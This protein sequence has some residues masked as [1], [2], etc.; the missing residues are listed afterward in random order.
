MMGGTQMV[1]IRPRGHARALA[2]LILAASILFPALAG[3]TTIKEFES[4]TGAQQ[5]SCVADFVEKMTSDLSEKNPQLA[6]DI[7][8]WFT[9]KKPGKRMSEGVE[10]LYVE[11]AAIDNLAAK[12]K[13][14]LNKIQLESVIV[15]V[16]K[17]KFPPQNAAR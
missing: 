5:A 7:R 15:Y 2:S 1:C 11:F 4:K 3:A 6:Q 17:E 13:L 12:G 14:D 9:A 16:V 10:R 8:V